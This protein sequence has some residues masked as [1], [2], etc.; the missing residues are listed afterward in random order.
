MSNATVAATR[1]KSKPS[2]QLDQTGDRHITLVLYRVRVTAARGLSA[3]AAEAFQ[4][5][6]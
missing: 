4:A 2:L 1:K 5:L 6:P 3:R